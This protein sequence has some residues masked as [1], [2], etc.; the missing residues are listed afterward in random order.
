ML[1]K[2]T[3]MSGAYET[4]A[5]PDLFNRDAG[6]VNHMSCCKKDRDAQLIGTYDGNNTIFSTLSS[7]HLVF[8]P[9]DSNTRVLELLVLLDQH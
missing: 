3:G 1:S 7:H 5:C 8:M 6:R 2:G 9:C 4:L